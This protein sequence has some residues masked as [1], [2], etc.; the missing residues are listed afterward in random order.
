[1]VC[2]FIIRA[3]N[4]ERPND[5][6]PTSWIGTCSRNFAGVAVTFASCIKVEEVKPDCCGIIYVNSIAI[7]ANIPIIT[8]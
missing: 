7:N 3:I 4:I 8:P 2:V 1:M 5:V 6:M